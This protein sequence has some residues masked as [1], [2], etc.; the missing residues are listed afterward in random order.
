MAKLSLVAVSLAALLGATQVYA[1]PFQDCKS[2]IART[3][4]VL[5]EITDAE[6]KREAVQ[7]LAAA[8]DL[9]AK[10]DDNACLERLL[11]FRE[12]LL[13]RGQKIQQMGD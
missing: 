5:P 12:R 13:A 7:E 9:M 4:S 11:K 2:A 1:Q 8:K 10:K 6:L 3:E